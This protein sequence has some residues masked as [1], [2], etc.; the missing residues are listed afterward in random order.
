MIFKSN[1]PILWNLHSS[2]ELMFTKPVCIRRY[3][4]FVPV[5]VKIGTQ[6]QSSRSRAEE[7]EREGKREPGPRAQEEKKRGGRGGGEH[8]LCPWVLSNAVQSDFIWYIP[9]QAWT[10]IWN[11]AMNHDNIGYWAWCLQTS[12]LALPSLMTCLPYALC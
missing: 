11:L 3:D 5:R 7:E 1:K 12:T 4:W 6:I 8:E 10:G 2:N 9:I